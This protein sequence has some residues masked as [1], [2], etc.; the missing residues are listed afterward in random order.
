MTGKGSDPVERLKRVADIDVDAFDAR[1][2]EEADAIRAHVEAGTFD[3]EQ[4]T[5]GLEYEFYAVDRETD[6][7]RRIPRS[8]LGCVGFDRELGLHNAE[9][10]SAVHPFTGRGIDAVRADVTGKLDAL[11]RRAAADGIRVV[12]DGMWTIGP[13][14]SA[15]DDYLTEATHEEG[16]TLGINVSNGVRYH[17]FASVGADRLIG[18]EIDVP[19]AR[20]DA[21]SAGPVSLTT[22]IQPHYQPR[23]AA[24]LPRY[25]RIATRLAGPLLALAVNSPFLP[26]ALYDDPGPDRE[27]LV[28]DGYAEHRIPVYEQMMNPPGRDRKVKFPRDIDS[29]GAAI[30]RIAADPVLVPAEIEAEGRFDDEFVHFRHKH[31]SYWRWVRPV[32]DGATEGSASAR[33]E[34]RPLPGQPT[35]PDAVAILAAFGGAMRGIAERGHPVVDLPW[36]R[37]E[38]NFYAAARNG[39]DAEMEWITADGATTTETAGLYRDLF[40]AAKDG[41]EEHGCTTDQIAAALSPL[42]SRVET[43]RTPADWKRSAVAVALDDG[44]TPAEAIRSTQRAYI[45]LQARTL[46]DESLA[47][48]P[49]PESVLLG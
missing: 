24:D 44:A 5:T 34:F 22:S 7:L 26:P 47:D 32:F 38:S 14:E 31:G 29:V 19:G 20:I 39:L 6:N 1:V 9:L 13:A 4:V 15:T 46:Y 2:R 45:R 8:L 16:L 28:A 11:Q 10:N 33:I 25:H 3:N 41:L 37:A 48:W 35:I 43:G 27:L 40:A 17:G 18:S 12:S 42:R 21:D 23:R 36:E 30:D 49:G